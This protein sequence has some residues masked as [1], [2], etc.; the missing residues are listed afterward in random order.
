MCTRL[1]V[2]VYVCVCVLIAKRPAFASVEKK[3]APVSDIQTQRALTL[4]KRAP[5]LKKELLYSKEGGGKKNEA[6]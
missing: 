1:F 6:P 2:C 5:T 3:T 4:K